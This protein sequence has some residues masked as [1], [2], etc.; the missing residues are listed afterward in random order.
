[1]DEQE[2]KESLWFSYHSANLRLALAL[3]G[4]PCGDESKFCTD[5]ASSE[6]AL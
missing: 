1:M 4:N 3:F 5:V 2:S 6:T